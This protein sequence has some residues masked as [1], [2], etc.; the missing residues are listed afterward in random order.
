M[1]AAVNN[2][3]TAGSEILRVT[4]SGL[5]FDAGSNFIDDYEEGTWTPVLEGSSTAGSHT[6]TTQAGDYIKIGNLVKASCLIII[7]SK[8]GSMAG[9]I[10]IGGLPFASAN[11]PTSQRGTAVLSQLKHINYTDM[12]SGTVFNNATTISL[13]ENPSG[14]TA[15][16]ATI[17]DTDIGAN[18]R[19][20]C[21]AIYETD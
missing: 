11:S 20:I 10:R 6:Y 17:I 19:I 12:I 4:T 5:S 9:N 21:Y 18:P 1:Y 2:V 16:A 15:D 13:Y 8:D 14:T 7:S 3:T